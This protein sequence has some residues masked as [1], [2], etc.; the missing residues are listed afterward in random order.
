VNLSACTIAGC[1]FVSA[2]GWD[3]QPGKMVLYDSNFSVDYSYFTRWYGLMDMAVCSYGR[4]EIVAWMRSE[5][6]SSI[7]N[8]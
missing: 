3:W 1:R 8:P 6:I 4:F 5:V 2:T 7:V